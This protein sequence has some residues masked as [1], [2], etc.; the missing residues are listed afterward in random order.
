ML[1][2][3]NLVTNDL[4]ELVHLKWSDIII[5]RWKCYYHEPIYEYKC[6]NCITDPLILNSA[7]C[8]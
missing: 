4:A 3:D 6:A 2:L 8:I 5:L 1:F 7:G